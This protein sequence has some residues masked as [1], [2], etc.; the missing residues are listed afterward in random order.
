MCYTTRMTTPNFH[1]G[2]LSPSDAA[3][4]LRIYGEGIAGGRATFATEVPSWEDWDAAHLAHSRLV[5]RVGDS[6]AGWAALSLTSKR[7]AYSG[8]A[9]A[10][11]Y[12]LP[13]HQGKGIGTVLLDRLIGSSERHGIWSLYGAI[14]AQNTASLA[15]VKKMGFRMIGYREK[16]ARLGSVW[17]DT[18][19]VE[20]RSRMVLWPPEGATVSPIPDETAGNKQALVNL[21]REIDA[22]NLD[23]I[24]RHYHVD[25]VEHNGESAK[26]MASGIG[27]VRLAFENFTRAFDDYSHTIDDVLAE[28]DKVSARV[29]FSGIFA[30]PIFGLAPTG[31][32]VTATG[33]AIYRFRDGKIREKWG[34]F[35]ALAYLG[36]LQR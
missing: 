16:I 35:N 25:Y 26:N 1:I 4:V 9:E 33:I 11:V 15:L 36:A 19:L 27:G 31:R 32:R 30:R 20:R 18:I 24:E 28:G 8:V 7:A 6:V 3:A 14:L 34:Y 23:C 29:T 12:I 17:K 2:E 22:R 5:A 10:S 13:E 21:L